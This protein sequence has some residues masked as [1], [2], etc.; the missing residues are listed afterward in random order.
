M[1]LQAFITREEEKFENSFKTVI[2][3]KD[4]FAKMAV[5]AIMN[6]DLDHAR[7]YAKEYKA[8]EK[9]INQHREEFNND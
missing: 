7:E 3:L 8:I 4:A 1:R 6:D 2:E 9:S 5:D